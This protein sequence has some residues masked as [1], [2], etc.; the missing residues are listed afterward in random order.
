MLEAC[1]R[2]IEYTKDNAEKALAEDIKTLDAVVRN[3]E[4]LGE[5]AKKIP[6]AF[7]IKH[8]EIEW[9]KITGLRDILVHEYF[10]VD[11][12][13]ILDVVLNKISP[14]QSSLQ[15]LVSSTPD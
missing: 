9:K 8:P 15:K 6:D 7:R 3:L 14:L 11:T 1:R 12:E 2:I 5:A 10:G 4:I 13:I